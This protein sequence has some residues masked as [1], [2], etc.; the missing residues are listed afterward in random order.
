MKRN[1]NGGNDERVK[2]R[3]FV[4]EHS[5]YGVLQSGGCCAK[6]RRRQRN[7]LSER[8]MERS[9]GKNTGGLKTRF[10]RKNLQT[11]SMES[12]EIYK[13]DMSFTTVGVAKRLEALDAHG[14]FALMTTVM[15]CCVADA[16]AVGLR[17]P[18]SDWRSIEDG[19][20]IM[21]SGKLVKEHKKIAFPNFRVGNAA[22]SNVDTAYHLKPEKIMSYDRIDQLP[23]LTAR[24]G[25]RARLFKKALQESG[26]WQD[27][28]QEGPFTV[29]VPVDQAI[30]DL[31]RWLA[32]NKIQYR[33]DL[34]DGLE[35]APRAINKLFDGSNKGKLII[36]VSEEPSF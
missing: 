28:E 11:V 36:K 22:L 9:P 24:F 17:V 12:D 8:G 7:S 14:S 31:R 30:E 13:N 29:F 23:L 35:N 1:M 3:N 16:F 26:L 20:W 5:L 18:S 2:E 19:Q 21:V 4:F 6:E 33:V 34:V 15:Y 10:P 27:L 32:Q 25:T